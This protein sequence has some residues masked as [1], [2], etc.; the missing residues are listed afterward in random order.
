MTQT[1]H[2]PRQASS[3]FSGHH[4]QGLSLIELMVA[5]SL[6]LLLML[7][8]GTIYVGSAQ[9]YRVQ[10]DFGRLQEAGRTA[11]DMIGHSLRQAGFA[12]IPVGPV[13]T[14]ISFE[15]YTI[16]GV[17]GAD[18]D[19]DSLVVQYDGTTGDSTCQGADAVAGS[20][21][22][23]YFNL[24]TDNDELQCE[25]I[26]AAAAG[27]AYDTPPCD[28]PDYPE[29]SP[30]TSPICGQPLMDNVEDLQFLYGIDTDADQTV[31]RY[32]SE[33]ANWGQVITVKVCVLAHSQNLGI[34]AGGGQRYLNCNG[35][36]AMDG[37]TDNDFTVAGDTRLRRAFV[38]TFNLRNR[39]SNMPW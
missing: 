15:G 17:N 9:T 5:M 38:A 35:A 24:D 34:V 28:D 25:G 26:N 23:D 36:L 19:P 30:A 11:L 18:G 1:R 13:D 29:P 10:D 32:T 20:V 27:I 33:P 4:E 6:G 31:N 8:I 21:I 12:D 7:A 14:K 39:V 3:G 22:Q 16:S 2:T 37:D